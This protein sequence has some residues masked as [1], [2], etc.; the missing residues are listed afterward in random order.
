MVFGFGEERKLGTRK[1]DPLEISSDGRMMKLGKKKRVGGRGDMLLICTE[2]RRLSLG[3]S[4][5]R[6]HFCRG[7][8]SAGLQVNLELLFLH[9]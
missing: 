1:Q 5:V 7:S 2:L 3:W 6:R 9:N 4:P 8:V